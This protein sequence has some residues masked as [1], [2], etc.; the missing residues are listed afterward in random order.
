MTCHIMRGPATV[1]D[2]TWNSHSKLNCIAACIQ[3]RAVLGPPATS[4]YI[5][6]RLVF[7]RLISTLMAALE[8]WDALWRLYAPAMRRSC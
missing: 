7:Y 1:Q 5:T 2:P 4:A 8:D 6:P 3:V